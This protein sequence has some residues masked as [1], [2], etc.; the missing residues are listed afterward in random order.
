MEIKD[1]VFED[2]TN[3]KG[4]FKPREFA[5][6]LR[7]DYNFLTMDET[8]TIYVQNSSMYKAKGESFIRQKVEKLLPSDHTQP[9]KVK[10]DVVDSVMDSTRIEREDFKE[11]PRYINLENGVYDIVEEKFFESKDGFIF[12]H[13]IP[14]KYD[15][16]A[17][18]IKIKNFLHDLVRDEDVKI[19][20]ELIGYCLYRD[21]PI[22][23]AFMLY[24]TGQNGKTTFLNMLE[25]F[26]G[27]NNVA[28]PSIHDLLNNRFSKVELFGKL[29]NI[30][31]DLDPDALESTGTFKRLTGGDTVRGERKYQSSFKFKNYA[32]LIYS[33]N[34]LPN[35]DDDTDAFFRR[36]VIIDFPY[37]FTG[38]EG[39][40]NKMIN[41]DILDEICTDDEFSGLLN[42]ALDGLKRV[43]DNNGFTETKTTQ[44]IKEKWLMKSDSLKAFCELFV[45]RDPDSCITKEKFF[46]VYRN[47]CYRANLRFKNRMKIGHQLPDI[48]SVLPERRTLNGSRER[49]WRGVKFVDDF[50][51]DDVDVRYWRLD[52]SPAVSVVTDNVLDNS[53]VSGFLSRVVDKIDEL[54]EGEGAMVS[55]LYNEFDDLDRLDDALNQLCND[56]VLFEPVQGVYR[57]V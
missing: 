39:D 8:E 33:A 38:V 32:K 34:E 27:K 24:N 37:K 42:W 11:D 4:K 9:K 21:Y 10:S 15:S 57:K 17:D 47:Y 36:W 6:T 45:E 7:N 50:V 49:V 56:G 22:A 12:R 41:P 30:N 13:E 25:K 54:D 23:K 46:E 48:L 53:G 26:L 29:A 14:V 52:V 2:F 20:Q 44:E 43:L 5:N 19:I 40:G 35:T 1:Y 18:C 3:E 31:G 55:D 28:N 16:D 51:L